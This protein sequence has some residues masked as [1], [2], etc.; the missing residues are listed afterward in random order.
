MG[1]ADTEG[2]C[3]HGPLGD[4]FS[5]VGGARCTQQSVQG[6]PSRMSMRNLRRWQMY[7]AKKGTR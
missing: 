3:G 2:G 7:E 5:E 6:E 4:A 1:S